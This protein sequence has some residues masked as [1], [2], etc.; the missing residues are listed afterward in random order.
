MF[1]SQ[2]E[3][4][5]SQDEV[6]DLSGCKS[7]KTKCRWLRERGYIFESDK[8]GHPKVSRAYINERFGVKNINKK[9]TEPNFDGLRKSLGQ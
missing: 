2:N 1:Q 4:W 9:V 7:K 6:Y 3:M 8:N 5:L